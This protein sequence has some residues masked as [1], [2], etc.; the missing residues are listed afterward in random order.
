M[1][2]DIFDKLDIKN[3]INN[4]Q[5]LFAR[6]KSVDIGGDIQT[7]YKL[8]KQISEYE[9]KPAKTVTNLDDSLKRLE[10]KANIGLIYIYEFVKIIE[11][12]DYLK[13]FNTKN[14]LKQWLDKIIILSNI[15]DI[16]AM[17]DN[18][19]QIK[20]NKNEDLDAINHKIKILKNKQKEILS[21]IASK[22][23]ISIYMVDRSLYLVHGVQC[24]MVRGGFSKVIKA[25]VIDRTAAGF[26]Y[27]LPKEVQNINITLDD[28]IEEKE[29]IL[30]QICK[31]I[32]IKF[33]ENLEF[34]TYI[35]KEFDRFDHYISRVL[36]AKS[37]NSLFILP[38]HTKNQQ[39]INF[40]HPALNNP[41]A[42]DIKLDKNIIIITGVNAG[43]KTMLLKSILSAVVLS[44]HLIPYQCHS[45]SVIG[46]F[47]HIRTVLDDPQDVK[48]DISTFAGRMLHFSK[49]L[50]LQNS[51]IGVDEIELGTDSDEASALFKVL[52]DK[53]EHSNNKIIVTTHHKRLAQLMAK[54]PQTKLIAAIYDEKNQ[55]PT[56]KFLDGTIGKSYAFETALRYHIPQYLVQEAIKIYGSDK[57]NLNT[58]ITKSENLQLQK[59]QQV[60]NLQD[61]INKYKKLNQDTTSKHQDMDDELAQEKQKLSQKYHD[62]IDKLKLISKNSTQANIHQAINEAQKNHKDINRKIFS[63]KIDFDI[64]QRVKYGNIKGKIISLKG[65]KVKILC[66]SGINMTIDTNKLILYNTPYIKPKK[67]QIVFNI[68]KPKTG[69]V[70]L[71]L[72]GQRA[73]EATANLDKF[74]SDSLLNGF[75]QVLV[76]HGIGEGKLSKV[77]KEFLCIHP[78]VVNFSDAPQHLGGYGAKIVEF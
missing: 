13:S 7:H 75:E 65:K 14:E 57:E 4:L 40:K 51:L 63:K 29:Q 62:I 52:L 45:S 5:K 60:N 30:Y 31:D 77:V 61:E 46:E 9:F 33:F 49:L 42:I 78:K 47:K 18:K 71:D 44:K 8:I 36:F 23:S 43:G 32:S 66:D 2:T 28:T 73:D 25:K 24:L 53:L 70:K 55:I 68:Q 59:Q 34:L 38:Q 3:Y 48:N 26:F 56:Y 27:I 37:N 54:N 15:Y 50:K 58:L 64:G 1:K 41:T 69:F 35:N 76:Y 11:Y 16:V 39:L 67:Q 12:F 72:H 21:Y 20:Q 10:K 22:K 6:E 74:L 17:F 19:G